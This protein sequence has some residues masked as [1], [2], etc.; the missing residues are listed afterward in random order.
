MNI[1]ISEMPQATSVSGSDVIP[2]VQ[3]GVSK[4]ANVSQ[5]NDISLIVANSTV[6][7]NITTTGSYTAVK[8]SVNN[9]LV[10]RRTDYT[11]SDGDIIV[12]ALPKLIEVN[13]I[14]IPVINVAG[15][16]VVGVRRIRNGTATA[17]SGME[18]SVSANTSTVVD[19]TLYGIIDVEEN[20]II[21][22]YTS[23]SGSG[24]KTYRFNANTGFKLTIKTLS[25]TT[26][27]ATLNS[28]NTASL[29]N[30]SSLVGM[31]D[32]TEVTN[33]TLEKAKEIE[34]PL[35]EV[36]DKDVV[37]IEAEKTTLQNEGSGDSK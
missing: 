32:R 20:D 33:E 24:S 3:S 17:I 30:T 12:G 15:G 9:A 27:T 28:L 7:N 6:Q 26:S 36:T 25:E 10:Q 18:K 31:G 2:I 11:I 14:A 13:L 8:V 22:V 23:T 37:E 34:Q 4:K 5:L 29:M 16:Y 19:Y 1:K 35:E 21:E